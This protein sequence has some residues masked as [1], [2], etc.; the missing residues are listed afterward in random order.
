VR[1]LGQA[2]A[3]GVALAWVASQVEPAWAPRYLAVL[4]GPAL[5]AVACLLA[6]RAAWAVAAPVVLAAV[7]LAAGPPDA[8]SNARAVAASAAPSVRAGDL[9]VCTQPEQVPVLHRYLPQGVV[10]L[11]PLGTPAD[12]SFTDWRDALQRLRA[13][14]AE[15]DLLPVVRRLESG[16]RVILVTPV[17]RPPRAPWSRAVRR[18]TRE[19]RAAVRAE[20]RLRS[21][22]RT[23]RPDPRRFRS[24]VRAEIF[25]VAG[26]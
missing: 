4:F 5:I 15:R 12:P 9:V 16:R 19:W 21:L 25:E 8:K 20:P 13:A 22:G 2:A 11:T 3:A 18:R 14:R 10:Y 6:R 24:A 23:S 7:W 1:V 17:A 26:G